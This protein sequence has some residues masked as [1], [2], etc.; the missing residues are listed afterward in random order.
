[1]VNIINP[2][3]GYRVGWTW[4][5]HRD[6]GFTGGT[7]Y[8]VAAGHHVP[9]PA[10]GVARA[11]AD[12]LNSVEVVLADGRIITIRELR[13]RDGN[14][15]RTVQQGEYIGVTGRVAT[16]GVVKWPHIDATIRGSRV[17][18]E[19]LVTPI[20][21][22]PKPMPK[23][24]LV[25][26]TVPNGATLKAGQGLY[27]GN[28]WLTIQASD[29]NM[30]WRKWNG[31]TGTWSVIHNFGFNLVVKT[32]RIVPT[33]VELVVQSKDNH[34]VVYGTDV[35]GRRQVVHSFPIGKAPHNRGAFFKVQ[36][37]D[38]IVIYGADKSVIWKLK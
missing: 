15:P 38:N 4:Q 14:F 27:A 10:T 12:G 7:D 31:H 32:K 33:S 1:M 3:H 19:P 28:D 25:T 35:H 34:V 20:P 22:P 36:S 6:A 37:D 26:D 17:P 16:N 29:G 2:F 5:Q 30:V 11:V 21:V 24:S 23:P 8:E 18:F 9:S 13:S